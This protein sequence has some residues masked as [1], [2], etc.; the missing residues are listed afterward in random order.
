MQKE[1]IEEEH[2]NTNSEIDTPGN[3]NVIAAQ[4]AGVSSIL[5]ALRFKIDCGFSVT[6]DSL[7]ALQS[8]VDTMNVNLCSISDG[9]F[10]LA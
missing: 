6:G 1:L 7:F 10:I 9:V 2:C 8:L 3:I 4:L 5:E